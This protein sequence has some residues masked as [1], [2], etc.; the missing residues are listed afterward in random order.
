MSKF[1]AT[2]ATSRFGSPAPAAAAAKETS[3]LLQ[4]QAPFYGNPE[5]AGA[6]MT[7]EEVSAHSTG[8]RVGLIIVGVAVLIAIGLAAGAYVFSGRGGQALDIGRD[9]LTNDY[10]A[11]TV[12]YFTIVDDDSVD[13]E[14]SGVFVGETGQ[15]LTA[16][17]CLQNDPGFCD[18]DTVTGQYDLLD[19]TD[20]ETF[21][22]DVMGING[23]TEKRSFQIDVLGWSGVTD[24]AI[25]Q[26]RPLTI[27][28][29][30]PLVDSV[31][32]ITKQPF[33]TFD[34]SRELH[35]G[36]EIRTLSFDLGFMKKLSH[37]GG[38]QAQGF[39]RG[40]YFVVSVDQV[41]TPPPP[42]PFL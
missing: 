31:I 3:S 16:V 18:F 34:D 32:N 1:S 39:D 11:A 10:E 21:W 20:D 13:V 6:V 8:N 30:F 23:G 17:H 24:V 12:E 14:C 27:S 35:R 15:I 29:G 7:P 4:V 41:R 22:V 19:R 9:S 38:V 37:R 28:S 2:G 5:Q 36:D 40:S 33:F 26:T 25:M 42:S